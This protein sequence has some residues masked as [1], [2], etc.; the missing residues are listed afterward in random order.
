MSFFELKGVVEQLLA[1]R[2]VAAR[3]EPAE[4]PYLHPGRQAQVM[5]A[6][7]PL[8]VLGEVHPTVAD[9][10]ELDGR[11]VYVAELD[12]D[13]L[14]RLATNAVRFSSLPRYPSVQRDMALLVPKTVSAAAVVAA[15]RSY[16][17]ELVESVELFDVYEGPQVEETHRSLAYSIRLRAKD[18]T[19]TDD[20]ANAIVGEIERGLEAEHGVRRRV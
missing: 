14:A 10:F 11:R 8:G 15:I 20:E 19:L 4:E 7:T 3:F 12:A 5:V 9:A 17:G 16:G 1:A 2:G 18:R 6:D 13:A